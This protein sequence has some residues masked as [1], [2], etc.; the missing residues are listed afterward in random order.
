MVKR[1]RRRKYSLMSK[2]GRAR[3]GAAAKVRWANPEWRAAMLVKLAPNWAPGAHPTRMGVP[4]GMRRPHALKLWAKAGKL[5]DGFIKTM[6]EQ[7]D[8][9]VV[10]IPGSDDEK[11]AQA[12]HEACKMALGPTEK[13]VKLAAINTVL[14]YTKQKPVTKIDTNLTSEKWLEAV[15]RDLKAP[16]D[17]S[18]AQP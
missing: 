9:P 12:L 7:G 5:A 15:V 6:Q 14:A 16:T 17:G 1:K 10:L 18:A 13:R 3:V 8:I 11:A 2:E 4:D